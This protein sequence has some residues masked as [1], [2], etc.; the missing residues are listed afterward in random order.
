MAVLSQPVSGTGNAP[1]QHRGLQEGT[2]AVAAPRRGDTLLCLI[3]RFH[4]ASAVCR[5]GE[6]VCFSVA[7]PA[8]CRD[9]VGVSGE[10]QF[11]HEAKVSGQQE[12]PADPVGTGGTTMLYDDVIRVSVQPQGRLKG[13]GTLGQRPKNK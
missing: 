13:I 6:I 5:Q 3:R 4:F 8:G 1:G 12:Q 9:A 10:T 2:G 11:Q 7:V